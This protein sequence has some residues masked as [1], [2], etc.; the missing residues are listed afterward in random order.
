VGVRTTVENPASSKNLAASPTDWQQKGQ[1]GVRRAASAPSLF[2]FFE[3][4]SIASFKNSVF[5]H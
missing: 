3:I 4:G 5:C 2:I 1:A